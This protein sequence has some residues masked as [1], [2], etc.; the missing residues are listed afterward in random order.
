M[1]E[2]RDY[3]DQRKVI[4]KIV[5]LAQHRKGVILSSPF[6]GIGKTY[7][8]NMMMRIIQEYDYYERYVINEDWQKDS[9]PIRIKKKCGYADESYKFNRSEDLG[10][11]LMCAGHKLKEMLDR[12]FN[13]LRCLLLDDLGF[14]PDA[15]SKYLIIVI[16]KAHYKG[17][18]VIIT[19]QYSKKEIKKRYGIST[20]DRLR[21]LGSKFIPM[22]GKNSYR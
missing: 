8:A 5:P 1:I 21:E 18:P 3:P 20:M 19:T 9:D 14:E 13:G 12:L 6:C 17:I 7:L 22:P 2:F 11:D 4:E 15:A 16:R 10:I